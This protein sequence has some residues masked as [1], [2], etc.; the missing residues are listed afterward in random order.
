[1]M[2]ILLFLAFTLT[3]CH[4]QFCPSNEDIKPCTCK[5]GVDK[6]PW[7]TCENIDLLDEL[8]KSLNRMQ[9]IKVSSFYISKS[10]LGTLPADIFR[11]I[12]M[13]FLNIRFTVLTGLSENRNRPA[14]LG[15]EQSLE[16]IEIRDSF[17]DSPLTSLSL[18]HLKK[19]TTL[20]L[21]GNLIPTIGNDW[22][23]SGP[24]SLKE[25]HLLDT[26][27]TTIGSHAFAALKDLRKLSLTGTSISAISREMFSLP[28]VFLESIDFSNNKILTLPNDIFSKMPSLTEVFLD[29]NDL[30]TIN[31]IS[32][33]HVWSHLTHAFFYGN[34][35]V[36]DK[37]IKW[38]FK[39]R[40]PE[41]LQG[42]CA[43]PKQLQYRSFT[44]LT[45]SDFE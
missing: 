21:E 17:I 9:D 37:N 13:K 23:E 8:Q 36:C 38:I 33:A 2:K 31:E 43:S 26:R 40:L 1:M 32:F 34:P 6:Q 12:E 10:Y 29:N 45:L 4:S 20:Q 5:I 14:F 44:N 42:H 18:S 39:Y 35:I 22:F 28:A 25:L 7:I 3:C 16:S 27:S 11:N 19:L 24:Y 41:S 15:Q 30:T